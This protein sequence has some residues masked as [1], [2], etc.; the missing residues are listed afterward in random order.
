MDLYLF[1][2]KLELYSNTRKAEPEEATDWTEFYAQEE[3][4]Y[5]MED[6]GSELW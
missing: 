5:E 6:P 1:I 4:N 3:A 2:Y